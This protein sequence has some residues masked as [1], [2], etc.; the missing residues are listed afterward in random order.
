MNSLE[1]QIPKPWQGHMSLS[2]FRRPDRDT[3]PCQGHVPLRASFF[4]GLKNQFIH[5][6]ILTLIFYHILKGYFCIPTLWLWSY[7]SCLTCIS[8]LEGM[9][10][11]GLP[12]RQPPLTTGASNLL[13]FKNAHQDLTCTK[14]KGL[15]LIVVKL[16]WQCWTPPP[17]PAL[18]N[19][20]K[21]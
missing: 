4:G 11:S 17:H 21:N 15:L 6:I 5:R 9:S 3:K 14:K 19:F 1:G 2:G 7:T 20:C 18:T 10:L 8:C 12:C 13:G 16:V